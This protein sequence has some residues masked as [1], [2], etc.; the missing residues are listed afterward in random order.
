M[1]V[2][3]H[4]PG[5]GLGSGLRLELPA[6][7]L[8]PLGRTGGGAVATAMLGT[9]VARAVEIVMSE[10]PRL[11]CQ[12]RLPAPEADRRSLPVHLHESS[13]GGR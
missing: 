1:R 4:T 2:P 13:I 11:G 7:R 10:I 12:D 8:D 3:W 6:E 5:K 9:G